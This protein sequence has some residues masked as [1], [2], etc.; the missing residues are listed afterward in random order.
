L[1]S[2]FALPALFAAWPAGKVADR[3][4]ATAVTLVGFVLSLAGMGA[5]IL[6]PGLAILL[7][8]SA[9]TG[10]GN[11]L[12]MLGQQTFV[13]RASAD[14]K[15]DDDFGMLTAAASVGQLVGPPA[16]TFAASLGSATGTMPDTTLGLWACLAFCLLAVPPCLWLWPVERDARAK[17]KMMT[18]DG[19][20]FKDVLQTKG[21]WRSLVVSGAVLVSVDLL[22]AFVPM[23]AA[24]QGIDATTVGLLLALRAG[25][26]VISRLG[27]ARLIR[28][29]GRKTILIASMA[30]AVA[31]LVALPLAGVPLGIAVM[32]GLGVGLGVP[33]PLTMAW[34]TS[35][36]TRGR[37][38][39]VLGLRLT[40]N[41]LAQVTMPVAVGVVA[42]PLGALG[43]FWANGALLLA[44]IMLIGPMGTEDRAGGA[45]DRP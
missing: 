22:Y 37:F 35:L 15:S 24:E 10:L 1:A 7:V 9:I 5:M 39:A 45:D 11:V 40:A 14:G 4:S 33:Q 36:T 38:G 19:H 42:A 23:W 12:L 25:I 18:P 2:A 17:R 27:L 41:R 8:A 31:A 30:L 13:A 3:K 16:I 34:A 26:S 21:L 32:I 29:F 43:V 6:V 20:K 44:A 28:R